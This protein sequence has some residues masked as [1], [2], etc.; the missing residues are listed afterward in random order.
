MMLEV[1]RRCTSELPL[2]AL[3]AVGTHLI[4][5]GSQTLFHYGLGHHRLGGVFFR[6]HIRFHH[7]YYARGHLV[8][9]VYR[10]EEGN[11]TPY[12]LIPTILVAAITFF[13]LPVDLFL[14]VA[15]ASAGSFYAHVYFDKV[16][17]LQESKFARFAWFRHKQQLHFVHHLHADTN[18]AVIDF[19]W[20]RLLGT[21]R[22]PDGDAM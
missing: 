2:F 21:Y 14:V 22:R 3:T 4:V 16:Y 11:N 19:F 18:F 1:A 8:S 5:S 9:S 15:A 13:V 20:D 17:H 12:F 6:N 10:S 7:A